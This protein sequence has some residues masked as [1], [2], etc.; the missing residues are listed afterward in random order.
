M[1]N[2]KRIEFFERLKESAREELV[3]LLAKS[4]VRVV[5]DLEVTIQLSEEN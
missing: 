5:G 1:D 4:S 2:E 3:R